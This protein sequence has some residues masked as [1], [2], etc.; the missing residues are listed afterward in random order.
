METFSKNSHQYVFIISNVKS[1]LNIRV[2]EGVSSV[3]LSEQISENLF[4]VNKIYMLYQ[5]RPKHIC[6]YLL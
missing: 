4:L 3:P 1:P 6:T 5:I 2:A